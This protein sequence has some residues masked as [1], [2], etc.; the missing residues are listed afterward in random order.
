[1]K[2]TFEISFDE[3]GV[4]RR[5]NLHRIFWLY[6]ITIGDG[7]REQRVEWRDIKELCVYK[8][9]VYIVDLICIMI[10]TNDDKSFELHEQMQNWQTL[11]DKLPEFLPNCLPFHEWFME[12][13][14]P[15][16]EFNL[17][18]VYPRKN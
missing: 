6:D 15:A 3:K 12:V 2:E 16:F 7:F 11:V 18:K 1:M 9:D 14:F 5:E 4:S 17:I 13:A 8:C 10:R